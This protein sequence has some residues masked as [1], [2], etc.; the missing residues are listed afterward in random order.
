MNANALCED[1]RK[2]WSTL[3]CKEVPQGVRV[4]TPLLYPDGDYIDVFV[5]ERD[6]KLEVTDFGEAL[7]WVQMQHNSE[8]LLPQHPLL[9]DLCQTLGVEF[10]QGQVLCRVQEE[11]PLLDAIIAVAQAVSQITTSLLTVYRSSWSDYN[12]NS[13]S[14]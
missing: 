6:G 3:E 1:I 8:P 12:A 11:T 9:N 5:V 14:L 10:S 7:G 4:R 2:A 13:R